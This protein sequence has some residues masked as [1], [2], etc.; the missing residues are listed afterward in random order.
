MIGRGHTAIAETTASGT[1]QTMSGDALEAHLAAAANA[2]QGTR[3]AT[4]GEMQIETATVDGNVVLTEQPPAKAG[5]EQAAM[6]ATA[7]HADYD[8]AGQWLHLTE[9][10]RRDGWRAGTDGGKTECVAGVRRCLRA[11]Q[12]QGNMD[13]DA[14][15]PVGPTKA[16]GERECELWRAGPDACYR[17]ER[18]V[19]AFDRQPRSSRGNA[20]LWQQGNSVTA[21][22]IVLDRT[23]QTLMAQ[24][25]RT[26]R[27]RF[28]WSGEC[29]NRSSGKAGDSQKQKADRR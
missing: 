23:K 20:R 2:Q 3:I 14:P 19:A 6:R 24:T 12:C 16:G 5:V 11:G 21:P 28:R 27:I 1:Q 10:P 15:E 17:R 29:D 9:S 7:G 4:G 13:G 22:V 8:N 26:A 25:T 18:G